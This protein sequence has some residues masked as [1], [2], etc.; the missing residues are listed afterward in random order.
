MLAEWDGDIKQAITHLEE[1]L[2]LAEQIG[3]PGEQWQI[4]AKLGELYM[5]VG[6]EEQAQRTIG[7]ATEITSALGITPSMPAN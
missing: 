3:L 5:V 7:R 4:L 6:D 1:A 2:S